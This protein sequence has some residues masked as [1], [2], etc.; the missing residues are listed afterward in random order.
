[1]NNKKKSRPKVLMISHLFPSPARANP[2]SG[3]FIKN[4]LKEYRKFTDIYLFIPV[5]VTPS[6]GLILQQPSTNSKIKE[7]YGQ[8]KRTLLIKLNDFNE[9]VP[10]KF[11]KYA[12]IPPKT[13]SSE[14]SAKILFKRIQF[15]L[16]ENKSYKIVHGQTVLPDGLAAIMLG[17]HL[18]LPTIIT[19]RGSDVHSI[20]EGSFLYRTVKSALRS[21]S[22]ITCVSNDLKKR[23]LNFGINEKKIVVIPNGVD[24]NFV[25]SNSKKDIR[26]HFQISKNSLIYLTIGRLSEVKDPFTLV[27]AFNKFA[28]KNPR[29]HLIVVGGG[30]LETKLRR[31]VKNLGL[32]ACVH[33]TGYVPHDEIPNYMN[34]CDY[35]CLSS[36]REGWPNVLFEAMIF[37]KPV[38]ATNVG[39]IPEAVKNEN[40]GILVRPGDAGQMTSAMKKAMETKWDHTRI[41]AYAEDNSWE[42]VA[43]KYNE[44]YQRLIERC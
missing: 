33:L 14:I 11:L 28:K 36:L 15:F 23:I 38:I 5:D 25:R 37:G 9:P 10:G 21:A 44:V 27:D 39:G 43:I 35:F 34:A 6:M 31:Y 16:K 41:K 7:L 18:K 32:K 3:I 30:P 17:E 22:L 2:N 19:V 12:S 20:K 26:K 42:K 8:L 40:Y 29:V 1:M 24:L 13:Y 4:Q